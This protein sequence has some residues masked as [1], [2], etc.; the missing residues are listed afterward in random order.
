VS[1]A[2]ARA[3]SLA[4]ALLVSGCASSEGLLADEPVRSLYGAELP[5]PAPDAEDVARLDGNA[6]DAWI[7]LGRRLSYQYRYTD[8]V[9]VYTEALR[10]HPDSHRLLRHRGHR[11]LTLR[12]FDAAVADLSRASELARHLPDATEPD[13]DP[14]PAGIPRST[15]WSN[16]QYHLA[17]AHY[18][19]GEFPDAARAW[20]EGLTVSA[21]DDSYVSAGWW[22]AL[23]LAR[24]GGS[25]D[26]CPT[27]E[28]VLAPVQPQMDILENH[29]Y[30]RLLLM[31]KGALSERDLLPD[32]AGDVESTT[33]SYGVAGWRLAHGDREGGMELCQA[34]LGSPSWMAFGFIAAE[35]ELWRA[36]EPAPTPNP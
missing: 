6:E 20:N 36:G 8:A 26:G 7:W 23:S 32:A 12:D 10:S 1:G 13:G 34:I 9:Q 25:V 24:A 17:L 19:R 15:T 33:I 4:C 14:N 2:V 22:L 29:A 30:H 3:A 28:Q 5:A 27:L 18:L 31:A 11:Y 35:A 21:N 16:I